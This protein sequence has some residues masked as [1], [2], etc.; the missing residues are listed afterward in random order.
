MRG[1]VLA[2]TLGVTA[3]VFMAAGGGAQAQTHGLLVKASAS[4]GRPSLA[5]QSGYATW[6]GED[7]DG[8]ITAS[9][10]RFDMYGLTAAHSAL[11]FNS[12][13]EVTNL[14]NGRTVDVRITDRPEPGRAGVIVVSKAA[15]ANLGFSRERSAPVRVR[16]VGVTR[17]SQTGRAAASEWR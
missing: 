17:V 11:P 3:A 9:G 4:S 13:V 7:F 5:E 12:V 1:W 16:V 6:Y 10:E 2:R 14:E 15:A 8:R